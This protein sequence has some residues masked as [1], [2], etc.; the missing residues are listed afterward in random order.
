MSR[1]LY[2]GCIPLS[3]A[4]Y[5]HLTTFNVV[6][7]TPPACTVATGEYYNTYSFDV[8]KSPK[9]KRCV[10]GADPGA[11]VAGDENGC[12]ADFAKGAYSQEIGWTAI[13][14]IDVDWPDLKDP[15]NIRA[16]LLDKPL[17]GVEYKTDGTVT[18]ITGRSNPQKASGE[19]V[20]TFDADQVFPA[21][22]ADADHAGATAN[23]VSTQWIAGKQNGNTDVGLAK[24]AKSICGSLKHTE[25][26]FIPDT[27]F[28]EYTDF[29]AAADLQKIRQDN[30]MQMCYY[31]EGE[32][33]DAW[34]KA[35]GVCGA[36]DTWKAI[37]NNALSMSSQTDV[38][39]CRI[40]SESN[41][42]GA[43]GFSADKTALTT[44]KCDAMA[45]AAFF[46]SGLDEYPFAVTP[47]D[48]SAIKSNGSGG[49]IQLTPST[50]AF[51]KLAIKATN[52][53]LKNFTNSWKTGNPAVTLGS[54]P[55]DQD[56]AA[57]VLQL[58]ANGQQKNDFGNDDGTVASA[59][60]ALY[61]DDASGASGDGTENAW[62]QFVDDVCTT[63]FGLTAITADSKM[64][65]QTTQ[66]TERSNG[67]LKMC[68]T[69]KVKESF[70]TPC[71]DQSDFYN[72]QY[73]APEYTD[74]TL[75]SY[76]KICR[77]GRL[78]TTSSGRNVDRD[79][80]ETRAKTEFYTFQDQPFAYSAG[81]I[82]YGTDPALT[83][84]IQGGGP[85]KVDS[86]TYATPGHTDK[87]GK[88]ILVAN[89]DAGEAEAA[90]LKQMKDPITRGKINAQLKTL[91]APTET[92]K[93]KALQ[94]FCFSLANKGGLG[95]PFRW[96]DTHGG[97]KYDPL[98]CPD[99]SSTSKDDE[100]QCICDPTTA[101]RQAGGAIFSKLHTNKTSGDYAG[102]G[103]NT[104]ITIKNSD[105]FEFDTNTAESIYHPDH[106][107]GRAYV[108]IEK[109]EPVKCK[110]QYQ[111][112][113]HFPADSAKTVCGKQEYKVC[114][115][116]EEADAQS[117]ATNVIGPCNCS[118]YKS[119]TTA[120]ADA[121]FEASYPRLLDAEVTK[122]CGAPKQCDLPALGATAKSA[123][124]FDEDGTCTCAGVQEH[125]D[126]KID[127][128]KPYENLAVKP[129]GD[130]C[131]TAKS[132]CQTGTSKITY[133]P[134]DPLT[135][136]Q[137][138]C[139]SDDTTK[140]FKGEPVSK[141]TPPPSCPTDSTEISTGADTGKCKCNSDTKKAGDTK[142]KTAKADACGGKK[143][144][145]WQRLRARSGPARG[146][147][148]VARG[149]VL[150]S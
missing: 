98:P 49:T 125:P 146:S 45:K 76:C 80:C 2:L 31:D 126:F 55:C 3:E 30:R 139:D 11:S 118:D 54:G 147:A 103:A 88:A 101:N 84:A 15:T 71:S 26:K 113:G 62:N 140:V 10:S 7:T 16:K 70:D 109:L 68:D 25:A 131:T 122:K 65:T 33:V 149:A 69:A 112:F 58:Y 89:F 96:D 78:L 34:K 81:T 97:C 63:V 104:E 111:D 145:W 119:R 95:G 57:G 107:K 87:A 93:T 47:S 148:G 128:I 18:P 39:Y 53:T 133:D 91:N 79:T 1:I 6:G 116:S 27:T 17:I 42:I 64:L 150:L 14:Q 28:A 4:F 38:S 129:A 37:Y 142:E 124:T 60:T 23:T 66:S 40:C 134:S 114:K 59:I 51:Q 102:C 48:G 117:H 22:A 106:Y 74:G 136:I 115:L 12:K 75:D 73:W 83:V 99:H 130:F 121:T 108:A 52:A 67:Q 56:C 77:K 8:G 143:R 44:A 90:L 29:P 85:D 94:G 5:P 32:K 137:C 127:K 138:T 82:T 132:T 135:M 144:H 110:E 46:L 13:K 41:E 105:D 21:L 123:D 92:N 61:K 35:G 120:V 86:A 100:T 20:Q 19:G 9:C 50:G 43:G 141:C 72:A 36:A 24:A